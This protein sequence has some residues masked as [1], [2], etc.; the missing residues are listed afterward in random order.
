MTSGFST[1]AGGELPDYGA[2]FRLRRQDGYVVV[3]VS[4][5]LDLHS[6]PHFNHHLGEAIRSQALPYVAVELSEVSF[7][8]TSG[9]NSVIVAWKRIKASGGHLVLVR[10]T[11]QIS[12]VLRITGMDRHFDVT[13]TLPSM[14]IGEEPVAQIGDVALDGP[15]A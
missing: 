1:P 4:G 11:K 3:E 12:S 5:D 14:A 8:D 13:D 15:T 7:F 2:R 9:L 10:P 6:A